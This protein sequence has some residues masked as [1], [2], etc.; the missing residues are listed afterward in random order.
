MNIRILLTTIAA[1]LVLLEN[2]PLQANT[3]KQAVRVNSV[4]QRNQQKPPAKKPKPKP[5]ARWR[6]FQFT[7]GRFSVLFPFKPKQVSQIQKTPLGEVN[8]EIFSV[9]P[10]NQDVSYVVIYNDFPFSYGQEDNAQLIFDDV[11]TMA[12]KTTGS[13]LVKKQNLNW[14]G[15]PGRELEYTRPKD[16][17]TKHKMYLVDGRLY[18]IIVKTTTEQEKKL[19]GTISGFL[20]SLQVKPSNPQPE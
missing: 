15:Y 17:L 11:Q 12:L 9:E 18:Q 4:M 13:S 5:A 8:L 19:S 3:S 6:R 7:E 1:T 16:F 14:N 2:S 20:N 10:P